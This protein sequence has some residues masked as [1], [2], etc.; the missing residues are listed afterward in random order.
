MRKKVKTGSSLLFLLLM[1]FYS[2]VSFANEIKVTATVDQNRVEIGDPFTLTVSVSSSST[3]SVRD[4]QLPQLSGLDLFHSWNESNTRSTFSSG[5]GGF[6]TVV[7][8]MY[9]Y[10]LAP[11]RVGKIRI[12]PVTVIVGGKTFKTKPIVIE[13][14]EQG[15]GPKAKRPKNRRTGNDPFEQ[16]EDL[17]NNLLKRPF[18]S[19]PNPNRN[20]PRGDGSAG[21]DFFI[22]VEV[23]KQEAYVGEQVTATWYLYTRG[24]VL[25]LDTLKYPD[26]KGFWK[27]DIEIATHLNFRQAVLNGIPY[28]KALLA[29]YALFPIKEG[30]AT[31]DP[32]RAKATIIGGGSSAFSF[33]RR[34]SSTHQSKQV[35]I[36]IKPLPEAGKPVNFSGGVGD[37]KIRGELADKTVVSGQPFEFN[38]RF[39]G[40]GLAKRIDSPKL[41]L[42]QGVEVYDK[43]SE[44][45][46]FKTG[47]SYKEFKYLLI[48]RNE[49]EVVMPPT[50]VSIFHPETGL[51]RELQTDELRIN[52]LPGAKGPAIPSQA[53]KEEEVQ[54]EEDSLPG[55]VGEY[56]S[57]VE[58]SKNQQ[59]V[60]WSSVFLFLSF[61]LLFKTKTEMGWGVRKKNI[62]QSVERRFSRI[63]SAV[64]KGDTRQVGALVTNAVYFVLGE[65]SRQGGAHVEL[66]KLLLKSP[67]SV[68]RELGEPVLKLME[69]FQ[70]MGFAPEQA[71]GELRDK[72]VQKDLVKKMESVLLNAVQLGIDEEFEESA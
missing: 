61:V 40:S 22:V 1:S 35:Q 31:I 20:N 66:E 19:Q 54:K 71:L 27:E 2:L 24:Q 18:G 8:Q 17:F 53:L 42:P 64:S 48:P 7:T 25:D 41:E 37:F 60:L 56:E 72:S 12:S 50:K 70:A 43:K 4:P 59:V 6:K 65:V 44:T 5:Q 30:G 3:V 39:D 15:K 21:E 68:R 14:L 23:D 49:G 36:M 62:M 55:M 67:P 9:N 69:S 13:S 11:K 58:V 38:I 16:M 51:Y 28:R 47:R 57:V 46:F 33:S 10:Q 63:N 29:S 32:Y 45:R 34:R 26:L 52:V